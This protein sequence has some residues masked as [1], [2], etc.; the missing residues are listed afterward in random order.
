MTGPVTFD[1]MPDE[2]AWQAIDP[3]PLTTY[4][5]EAG[6]DPSEHSEIRI[7]YSVDYLY[8]GAHLYDSNPSAIQATTYERNFNTLTSDSFGLIL[9]TYNNNETGVAF[10]AAPTGARS[11]FR[12]SNDAVG[13]SPF[14]WD[15]D[16]F[17]DLETIRNED[18]WFLEMRIPL[19]SLR[20]QKQN[21]Q[22]QMGMTVMRWIARKNESNI[23]P[24]IPNNWGFLGHFKPSQTH[25]VLFEELES[26]SPLQITPYLLGGL[27]QNH[28]L[29]T[30]K[31]EYNR[32]DDF[33]RE[34]GLDVKY[35]LGGNLTL[36]LTLNTD[37]AQV[38]ADNEQVNLTR[39][40][41]FFPEK[42]KFFQERSELFD[43]SM[44]GPNRLFY[45]RRIGIQEGEKVRILG[46]VR[47]TGSIDKWDLGFLNMQTARG[48][49]IL[50]ENFGTLRLKRRV[51]NP[52]SF[53]GTIFTTRIN[54]EGE[55]NYAHGLDAT[56]HLFGDDYLVLNYGQNFETGA[57]NKLASFDA[58]RLRFEWQTRRI[59]GFGYSIGFSRNGPT[60]N[61]GLGFIVRE[62]YT[63]YGSNINYGW[64]SDENSKFQNHQ[65][66]F[67]GNI[68][69]RNTGGY[70][71]TV[72][73]G[74]SWVT[75]WKSG[76]R[77][78]VSSSYNF[79]DLS[80]PFILFDKLSVSDGQYH[81]VDVEASF[82]T[83]QADIYNA[84]VSVNAGQFFDGYRLSG[85]FSSVL[86]FSRHFNL[87]PYYEINR[88]SFPDRNESFTAHIWRIRA[89]FYLNTKLSVMT[90]I[91]YSNAAD[92]AISNF[93]IR[94]NPRE[95][96]DLYIVYNE[97][98][99]TNRFDHFPVQP[100]SQARAIMVKY[101]YTFNL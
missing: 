82:N 18:G 33:T 2:E 45:S 52:N 83:P 25:P 10:F 86:T 55:Y 26:K 40:S 49:G 6:R 92:L 65:I 15:W 93:R 23:F 14:N 84:L 38:E 51:F 1:G 37:F 69:F 8:V 79:E 20:F 42:R 21:E 34:A 39:F 72:D 30:R 7:G 85:D 57:E 63:R 24:A 95:G 62:E 70:L 89:E 3:L 27:H 22:V 12:I 91:Q 73:I 100:F 90:F 13:T 11:E 96:N 77:L 78:E 71:E 99:N 46:G 9:D 76:S 67:G 61:P 29:N 17:W 47:L 66:E 97:N 88:V 50:S 75:N 35:G 54:E 94:Y 58:T 36:D 68:F 44:G 74:P 60:F 41:L 59:T 87:Q 28:Q 98:L 19:S 31:T 81:F 80:E 101:T 43:F 56:L 16:T 53:I 32:Q 48:E 5:P 64:F 4:I